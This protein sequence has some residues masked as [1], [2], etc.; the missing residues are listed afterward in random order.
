MLLGLASSFFVRMVLRSRSSVAQS[1][2][3]K[4]PASFP[5]TLVLTPSSKKL[6]ARRPLRV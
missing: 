4:Q 3:V 2:K 1:T 5:S 6:H